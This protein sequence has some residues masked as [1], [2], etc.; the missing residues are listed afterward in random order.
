GVTTRREHDRARAVAE[1]HGG[2]AVALVEDA[3]DDVGTGHQH[4]PGDAGGEQPGGDGQAVDEA[5]ARGVEVEG[6]GR[7][8]ERG[9]HLGG[10]GRHRVVGRRRGDQHGVELVGPGAGP[11]E[12]GPA[13][14]DGQVPGRLAGAG[15]AAL[16]DAGALD[17]PLVG[18]VEVAGEVVVGHPVR[19]DG[20]APAD[21]PDA[22]ARRR[23][24]GGGGGGSLGE[25]AHARTRTQA[26]GWSARTRSPGMAS[27]PMRK[28]VWAL[29]T[30]TVPSVSTIEPTTWPAC[31]I[32]PSAVTTSGGA[33][34]KTPAAGAAMSRS[35]TCTSSAQTVVSSVTSCAGGGPAGSGWVPPRSISSAVIAS[36]PSGRGPRPASRRRQGWRRSRR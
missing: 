9:G 7:G 36:L 12:R 32:S 1:E 23:G 25:D 11:V 30:S 13:G 3:G 27:R 26:R 24:G 6:A 28:P 2:L 15:P 16:S 20:G 14:G 31:T 18:G 21:H 5:G 29:V 17:D 8:A 22:P 4:R 19:G 33:A 35:G 34:W 10:R